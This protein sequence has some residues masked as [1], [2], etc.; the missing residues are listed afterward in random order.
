MTRWAL[1]LLFVVACM[2]ADESQRPVCR[3]CLSVS[4]AS[5]SGLALCE[6]CNTDSQCASGSCRFYAAGTF[7]K[8]SRSC[9]IGH[10]APQC[11]EAGGGCNGMGFCWCPQLPPPLHDAGAYLDAAEPIDAGAP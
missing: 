4:D 9:E 1:V 3:G 10:E 11:A 5:P 2:P 6:P 8:C 7:G